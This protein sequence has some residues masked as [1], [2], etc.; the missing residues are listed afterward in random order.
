M[1]CKKHAS[2]TIIEPCGAPLHCHMCTSGADAAASHCPS[3][4]HAGSVYVYLWPVSRFRPGQRRD[5]AIAQAHGQSCY[6][7]HCNTARCPASAASRHVLPVQSHSCSR[8]YRNTARCSPFAAMH[9]S[10]RPTDRRAP[11]PTATPPGAHTE[12]RS[13][14]STRSTDSC[15]PEPTAASP[16]ARSQQRMH[17]VLTS[18]GHSC[19][20]IHRSIS[21]CPLPAA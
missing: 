6:R 1:S 9:M 20:R 7:A 14:T 12:R 8:A 16:G 19:S 17:K 10:A 4:I 5:T 13:H 15:A 3:A 11:A 18:H 2:N 21:R